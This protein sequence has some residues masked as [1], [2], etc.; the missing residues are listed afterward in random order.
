MI[1]IDYNKAIRKAD[2]LNEQG[3]KLLKAIQRL[4]NERQTLS[5]Q[6]KGPAADAFQR[7]QESLIQEMQKA[8]SAIMRC[9]EDIE[10]TVYIIKR[11]DEDI[12]RKANRL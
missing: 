4:E 11:Q 5:S 12:A 10:E 9:A 7:R 3:R 6:W 1:Q 8:Y 2:E